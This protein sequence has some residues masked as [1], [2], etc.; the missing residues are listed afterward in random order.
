MD[1]HAGDVCTLL[2]QILSPKACGVGRRGEGEIEGRKGGGMCQAAC[3]R[4]GQSEVASE[5]NCSVNNN[6]AVTSE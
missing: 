6:C 5:L 4:R 2:A 1:D 3:L